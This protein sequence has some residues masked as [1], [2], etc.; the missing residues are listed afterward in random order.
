MNQNQQL[1]LQ[2]AAL[3]RRLE[4]T[5]SKGK[6][7]RRRH[8]HLLRQWRNLNAAIAADVQTYLNTDL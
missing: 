4:P 6:R 5:F 1:H 2:K 7:S 8:R 3:E